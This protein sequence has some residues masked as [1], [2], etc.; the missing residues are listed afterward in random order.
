MRGKLHLDRLHG[1]REPAGS[2]FGTE[3][4]AVIA[5][6]AG[7]APAHAPL[8]GSSGSNRTKRHG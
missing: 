1:V 2:S 4:V 8:K 7:P 6:T 3:P 5:R